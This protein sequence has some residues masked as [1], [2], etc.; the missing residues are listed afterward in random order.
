V[1]LYLWLL[2][3]YTVS[4]FY[5]QNVLEVGAFDLALLEWYPLPRMDPASCVSLTLTQLKTPCGAN[6]R[7]S[8]VRRFGET[9]A[10]T[11]RRVQTQHS[12]SP[13]RPRWSSGRYDP[14]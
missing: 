10:R 6:T 3:F 9:I 13:E 7:V 11:S 4:G 5:E 14:Q 12:Y 1:T 8:R 2:F